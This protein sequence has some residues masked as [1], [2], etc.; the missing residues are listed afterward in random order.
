MKKTLAKFSLTLLLLLA[1]LTGWAQPV[2]PPWNTNTYWKHY[3]ITNPVPVNQTFP[4]TLQNLSATSAPA[5]FWASQCNTNYGTNWTLSGN[6]VVNCYSNIACYLEH[7]TDNFQTWS[8]VQPV[9][10]GMLVPVIETNGQDFFRLENIP[11]KYFVKF[12]TA[13]NG[14]QP[15]MGTVVPEWSLNNV[16]ASIY[17][18]TNTAP[19]WAV[20]SN[21]LVAV[22]YPWSVTNITTAWNCAY[23]YTTDALGNILATNAVPA[24]PGY[25]I[26]LFEIAATVTQTRPLIFIPCWDLY[27]P[28]VC[29]CCNTNLPLFSN[30]NIGLG[31]YQGPSL[32]GGLGT[33]NAPIPIPTGPSGGNPPGMAPT[34]YSDGTYKGCSDFNGWWIPASGAPVSIVFP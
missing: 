21:E 27:L 6:L 28:P 8:I 16:S 33:G 26:R 32:D 34:Y 25:T 10:N 18:I 31:T 3:P 4:Y 30:I 15:R 20:Y 22:Y 2:L 24:D 14:A 1:G 17:V 9:T 29:S 23:V 5:L 7:S 12:L 13:P 19:T 11:L